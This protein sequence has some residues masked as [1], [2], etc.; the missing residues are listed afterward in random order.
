[1]ELKLRI[2]QRNASVFAL[3]GRGVLKAEYKKDETLAGETSGIMVWSLQYTE[4]GSGI[5]LWP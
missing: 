2:G 4:A 5:N 3:I 1:M